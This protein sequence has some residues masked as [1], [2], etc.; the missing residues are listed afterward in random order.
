MAWLY[1]GYAHTALWY[2]LLISAILNI[3]MK[4]QSWVIY[5]PNHCTSCTLSVIL[6]FCVARFFLCLFFHFNLC[7]YML[8]LHL[9]QHNALFYD[10]I[11]E[12][13]QFVFTNLNASLSDIPHIRSTM[14]IIHTW[15]WVISFRANYS[16]QLTC[17]LFAVT[18][19]ALPVKGLAKDPINKLIFLQF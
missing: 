9:Y 2:I 5:H 17:I 8:C 6:F 4:L 3:A 1:S 19:K 11:E 16:N 18:N 12:P 13:L 14:K 7:S 10:F 15:Q